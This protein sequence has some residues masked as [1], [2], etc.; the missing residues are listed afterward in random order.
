ME[1]NVTQ[2]ESHQVRIVSLAELD[3]V[4]DQAREEE[5]RELAVIP[6]HVFDDNTARSY[7]ERIQAK[8]LFLVTDP[9][10]SL[11]PK[12]S[13]LT[14]LTSLT[15]RGNEIGDEGAKAL[16]TLTGLTS[17]DLV[18]N[19]IGDEGTKALAALT[20]LTSLDLGY[21][22][23]GCKGAK[24]LTA[25]TGLTFLNLWDN[26][27]GAEGA[28]ALTALTGLT[29]L[30]LRTNQIGCKGAKALAALTGLTSLNLWDNK[31]GDEGAKALTALTGLTSLDLV[32][33][34]IGDEGAK[35]LTAL[36][37]LTS[38]DL[39]ANQIGDEGAKA[40]AALT[41]LTSLDLGYN[42]IGCKGAKALTKLTG[43]TFLY[44]RNNKIGAEG[45]K[46]LLDAWVDPSTAGRLREL[47]LR[48]NGDLS[49]VLP[50]EALYTSD[51]QAIFAAY[52]RYRSAREQESL[53]PLSEA[54]LLVVGNEAVG[55][56]SLVR[57]LAENKPRDR[58]E[59]KTPGAA[60]HEKIDTKTWAPE[61]CSVALN[62]WD[63]GGQ[64]IMH[65][66]HRYFLTERSLYLLVLEARRED[67]RSV[68]EWL[69]TIRSRGGDSPVI[70]VINKCDDKTRDLKLDETGLKRDYPCIVDFV[71]TCCDSGKDAA[72]SIDRLRK[73]IVYTLTEDERLKHVR[74]PI[75]QS[76]L[77]VKEAVTDMAR[78]KRV[79]PV[80]DFERLCEQPVSGAEDDAI[81]DPDE[82]RML[83]RLLND[84]GVV[85]AHGLERD[86]SALRPD[87]TLLDP[88]WL[89]GA[90]YKLLNST[91]I[92]DMR[93]EFTRNQLSDLLD[94]EVYPP[95]THGF[96]L[97]M[98][99]HPEIGLC[100]ALSD[101][102]E[103]RYLI[104]EALPAKPT[105]IGT[106][107]S[108]S[109][110]FRYDY[111][112]LPPGLIPR[113]IV[114]AHH[115]LTEE[116]ETWRSGVVLEAVS[117][118]I[119]VEADRDK[120]RIDIS[121]A[122]M[123]DRRRSALNVVL[124]HLEVV[125]TH[126][127]EIG[128]KARVPLPDKLDVDVGYD[129]LMLLEEKCGL[130]HR[131]YPEGADRIYTVGELLEGV[132]REERPSQ[133]FYVGRDYVHVTKG[134]FERYEPSVVNRDGNVSVNVGKN[135][136]ATDAGN[137]DAEEAA[138]SDPRLSGSFYLASFVI[139]F[140]S[141]V[142]AAAVLPLLALPI[143]I[144]GAI[145]AV[146]VIGALQLRQDKRL[147]DKSFLSLMKLTFE[148]FPFLTKSS[149]RDQGKADGSEE[150]KDG[151]DQDA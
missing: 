135:T 43:L 52:R 79:L 99:M 12:L 4:L 29:S 121:V 100:F 142:V 45:A 62:V 28:K 111:A 141:L 139:V 25:L 115:N 85:V 9:I 49:S 92:S 23:I 13:R 14:G 106:W 56:T 34:E 96:I 18:A 126:N 1:S 130:E 75:P 103:D 144:I 8:C 119:L 55:K 47:D 134:T 60:I 80:R 102:L 116:S 76:W 101:T 95:D 15:L 120:R 112:F 145:L 30:D 128:Q 11:I 107:P 35:A 87:I 110:R 70:V 71:R 94:A 72:D 146:S 68:Y 3:K 105:G 31:I 113:F 74:D 27:I 150:S 37:G 123:A 151:Q 84:L 117:C 114:Q 132:R 20:S 122:G 57:Y 77:R 69:K 26:E 61:G 41:G 149:P 6:R 127:Q 66:T 53:R 21:N 82:Q 5:W 2:S 78:E 124:D 133:V 16:T 143:V 7:A 125:H 17:L 48:E 40:L 42:Q 22:Q 59:G 104:P 148:Q 24:A 91:A 36:T 109:L 83:L 137:K 58:D 90:I 33:N 73:L 81:P 88:N 32:A 138:R 39:V 98:M 19:Q 38:L 97:G 54:K 131:F 108:D 65:G 67:D 63:F 140:L 44:L 50:P 93:G 147:S 136:G 10:H 129:H 89:T 46:T 51:A 118:R 86:A 64:E